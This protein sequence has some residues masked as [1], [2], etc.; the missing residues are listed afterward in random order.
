MTI[1]MKAP[2]WPECHLPDWS[3]D[4]SLADREVALRD[5]MR[6]VVRHYR[7]NQ[8]IKMW[9]VENAPIL[10]FGKDCPSRESDFLQKEIAL[11][12]ASDPSRQILVTDSGEFGLWYSAVKAGDVFGSTMYREAYSPTFGWLI[13]VIHYPLDASYFRLKQKN[14]RW[15]TGEHDKKIIVVELQAEPWGSVEV[16]LL[17]YSEQI[18]LFSPAYFDETIQFARDAGFNEY[19]LWGAEW[20]YYVREKYGESR[21]WERAKILLRGGK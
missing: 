20:W 13:G 12:R 7:D 9:Q 19:Y 11:V 1:G 21:Y 8:N 6:A 14:I 3:R 4:L 5:Y 10:K 18:A 2:R 15:L 17:P 16:P